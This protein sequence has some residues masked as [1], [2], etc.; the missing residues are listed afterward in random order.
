MSGSIEKTTV[1]M[2]R[3]KADKVAFSNLIH[4]ARIQELITV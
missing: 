2:H 3:V 1:S 4:D